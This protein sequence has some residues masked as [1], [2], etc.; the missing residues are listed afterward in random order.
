[1]EELARLAGYGRPHSSSRGGRQPIAAT[2]L[3]PAADDE[4]LDAAAAVSR[5][6]LRSTQELTDL[7]AERMSRGL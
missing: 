6:R 2:A 3:A 1:M 7:R 5:R 4:L